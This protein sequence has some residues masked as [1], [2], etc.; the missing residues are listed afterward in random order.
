[1]SYTVGLS[2]PP[3]S[4]RTQREPEER[5]QREQTYPALLTAAPPTKGQP[6]KIDAYIRVSAVRGRS[7]ETFISPQV[8]EDR[9]RAWATANGHEVIA[10]HHE[11]DVSGGKM[12]RPL[13]NEAMA[14]I[15]GGETEG[16]VVYRLDRFGRT[17][18]GSL[19]L[20]DRIRNAGA[21]FAS[22][23]DSFDITTETG[24]LVLNIMLSIAQ[25]ERERIGTNWRK[26][27]TRAVGRGLH[28]SGTLP[29]RLP[30][31][32]GWPT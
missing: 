5:E 23:S 12:D 13:L 4:A 29:V 10:A 18:V 17:L 16:I 9:I 27:R 32:R 31:R 24:R 28:I 15:E 2:H 7:G 30:A 26:A 1:M 6:M 21:L 14:R 11:L 8:Q 22:V 19:D 25:Y 3:P 20:I